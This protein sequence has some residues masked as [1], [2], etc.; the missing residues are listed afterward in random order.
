MPV[1]C[2]RGFYDSSDLLEVRVLPF[3]VT[4]KVERGR[5]ASQTMNVSLMLVITFLFLSYL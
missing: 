5:V 1:S 4:T 3:F 2:M